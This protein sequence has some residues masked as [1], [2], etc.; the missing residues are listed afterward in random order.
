MAVLEKIGCTTYIL[1][2][3]PPKGTL[4]RGTAS[5]GVF[6]VKICAGVLGVDD[7]NTPPKKKAE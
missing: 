4:M 2:L 7:L 5:F 3:R 1:V 6:C